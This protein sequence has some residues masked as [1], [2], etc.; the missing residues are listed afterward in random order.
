MLRLVLKLNSWLKNKMIVSAVL[1]DAKKLS[2][3]AVKSKA[4]WG[5]TPAQIESWQKELTVSTKIIQECRVSKFLID[6]QIA[7][8]YVLNPPK[9][10]N[11]ELEMLFVLPPFIGKGIGSQLLVDAFSKAEEVKAKSITLL[12]DPNAVSFYQSKGFYQ[13][14]KKEST[15][16]GRFLWV[17]KKDV[18]L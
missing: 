13:I 9:E 14:D 18:A 7:G 11:I 17:M 16:S 6:D 2:E 5:Y 4:F 15:I 12:S 1:V 10:E 3:I 8:F